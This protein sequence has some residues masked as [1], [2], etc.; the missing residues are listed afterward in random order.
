MAEEIYNAELDQHP[1]TAG[2]ITVQLR[3]AG[4]VEESIVDGPGLRLSVFTQGCFHNCPGCHNPVTHAPD[5]GKMISIA[6]IINIYRENPLLA[7]VTLSGGEPFLQAPPLVELAWEIHSL[8]GNIV[9]YTGY[10][11]EE[12]L[13]PPICAKEGVVELV[14]ASD[15]IV[16][17]PYI[18][19]Q[20]SMDL[21]FRGSANQRIM[22]QRR[23]NI[24]IRSR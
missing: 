17:G 21:L 1:A 10:L 24:V 20:K 23:Q 11:L 19:A 8:G 3:V 14:A 18:E 5:G 13:S 7:G 9:T 16:D 6:E 4:I 2:A 22:K 12:L 15:I